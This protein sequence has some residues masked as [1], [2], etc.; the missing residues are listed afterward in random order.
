MVI[1]S[2]KMARQAHGSVWVRYGGTV[3]LVT[4]VSEKKPIKDK[5]FAPL[6]V[7]YREKAY[8]SGRIPGG[9]FKRENRLTIKET[10][11][12][13]LIDRP[14]RPLFPKGFRFETQVLATVLSADRENDADVLSI[15][16]ASAALEISDIQFN[17]P[18]A[19]VR[20]GRINGE[21]IVNPTAAQVEQSD[22]DLVVAGSR[23]AVIMVEGGAKIVPEAEILEAIFFGHKALQPLIDIQEELRQKCGKQRREFTPLESTSGLKD[24]IWAMAKERYE[25]ALNTEGKIAR[26]ENMD[27]VREEVMAALT[28]DFPDASMEMYSF[29]EE[30][31][32]EILREQIFRTGQRVDKR[33]LTDIRNIECEVGILP[34]THGSALFT[35][36][37]T[38]ALATVTLGTRQD[39]QKIESLEGDWW[40]S[41]LLHYNFPPFSVGEVRTRMMPGRREIGHGNLAERALEKVIPPH[42]DFPYTVRA[43][44][45]ILESNGSSSM[46]S[47]CAGS[48]A[49]MDA[50]IPISAPVA[51]IAMGLVKEGEKFFI[52]SDILGDE[53]HSGD[54]DFKVAGT[55]EGITAFQMDIKIFGITRQIMDEALKQAREGRLHILSKMNAVM[56]K[57]RESLSPFA[58]R[59]E[60]LNIPVDRIRDV[61][62]PGGKMIKHIS[63]V[64]GAQIDVEDDGT[65]HVSS[66]NGEANARAIEMITAV[67]AEAEIGKFY[68]GKVRKVT[69]FGAFVEVLPGTDGLVHISQLE[70][71]RVDRVTDV[72]REG[73]EV[74]VKCIG[75]DQDGKISLSRKDALGKDINGNQIE[76][77]EPPPPPP[78]RERG[79]EDRGGGRDDYDRERNRSGGGRRRGSDGGGGGRQRY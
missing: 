14:L 38:Q 67:T 24:R 52:L 65:I 12:S 26:H 20:V 36:G 37:E 22:I 55:A 25:K 46:A 76:G 3:V 49:L 53:D 10:L 18:L 17:G 47:V 56:G 40:K 16:G 28:Q 4:V 19:G 50:G 7:E 31:E 45:E 11:V 54:M 13:R 33:G 27:K 68:K 75:I 61:I 57:T 73:D 39:E 77:Y 79:R 2:G 5:D 60:T 70:H 74:M 41:F 21:F 1:E 78:Q 42:E 59:I 23:D 48:L 8:A 66:L 69:D 58:P 72:I 32:R 71:Y 30:L 51:G 35:R 9:F 62:G 34:Q 15:V 43:V 6:T 63:E 29:F 64:T 44:S